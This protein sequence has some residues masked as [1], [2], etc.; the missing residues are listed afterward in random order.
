[1]NT[2]LPPAVDS[3]MADYLSFHAPRFRYL[4]HLLD[5]YVKP[6]MRVLD[7]GMSRLTEMI[8]DRFGVPVDAMGFGDDGPIDSGDYYHLD[9]NDCQ[10]SDRCRRDLPRYD[11]IVFA[12]VLEHLYTSP[13][14]VLGYLAD[15][16][17]PG[18]VM[19]V[20]TPNGVALPRRVGMLMGR[21]P[22]EKIREDCTNPGHF[23]EYT[24]AELGDYCAAVGLTV[25]RVEMRSY[26]NY[27]YCHHGERRTAGQLT[28]G[29]I[30]NW[31]YPW[32]PRNLRP[33]LTVVGRK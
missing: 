7:I 12:E 6:G 25:E 9:L 21:N 22:Y 8:H 16:L 2:L 3:A 1:M 20:Q 26:F 30:K 32:L 10:F 27:R 28:A 4:L 15:L 5:G 33:G 24:A 31:A 23:R 19:I 17:A 14:L 13:K 29:T 18:G 11:V